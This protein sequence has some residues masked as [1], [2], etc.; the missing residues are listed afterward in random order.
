[1]SLQTP[2]SFT[3]M[4]T[5]SGSPF[6]QTVP[7]GTWWHSAAF[8]PAQ[9]IVSN[10]SPSPSAFIHA[11]MTRW[12]SFSVMLG[13]MSFC[14]RAQI[15]SFSASAAAMR[16]ISSTVFTARSDFTSPSTSTG[17]ARGNSFRS[18]R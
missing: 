4:S 3:P 11:R 15:S 10:A 13:L 18:S 9:T 1:M 17:V 12:M 8:A 7:S 16:V 14:A 5:S 6:R 2:S